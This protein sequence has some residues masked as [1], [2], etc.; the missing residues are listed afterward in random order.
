MHTI[1][2]EQAIEGLKLSFKLKGAIQPKARPRVTEKGIGSSRRKFAYMPLEYTKWK[3]AAIAS[4]AEQ[5]LHYLIDMPIDYFKI[6]I[7]ITGDQNRNGDLDNIAGAI[8]DALVQSRVIENDNLNHVDTQL[9]QFVSSSKPVK[10]YIT[11]Y[12]LR[13]KLTFSTGRGNMYVSC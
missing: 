3:N 2:P 5:K 6:I 8:L 4:L 1:Q 12:P 13:R 10:T 9:L 7:L 11:I